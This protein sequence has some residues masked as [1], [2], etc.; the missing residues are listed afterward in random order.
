M[1]GCH[2]TST[3]MAQQFG[4]GS[5][6]VVNEAVSEC[7]TVVPAVSAVNPKDHKCV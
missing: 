4:K 7:E 5:V 6:V 3:P 2:S 1:S